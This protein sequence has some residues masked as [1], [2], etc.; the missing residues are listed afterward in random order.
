MEGGR[1]EDFSVSRSLPPLHFIARSMFFS[2]F[3]VIIADPVLS[4]PTA[5]GSYSTVNLVGTETR[6]LKKG[7]DQSRDFVGCESRPLQLLDHLWRNTDSATMC[8]REFGTRC[9]VFER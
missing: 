8:R 1:D 4:D 5:I 9:K 6:Q 7:F 2:P 3:L